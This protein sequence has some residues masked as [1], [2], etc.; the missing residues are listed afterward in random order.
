MHLGSDFLKDTTRF[1]DLT[2]E[3]KYPHATNFSTKETK[4]EIFL[5]IVW[6]KATS[7]MEWASSLPAS[8]A[9]FYFTVFSSP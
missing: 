5:N 1:W 9:H 2:E 3:L 4:Y 8:L 6:L 7:I